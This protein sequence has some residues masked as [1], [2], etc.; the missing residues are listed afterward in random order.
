MPTR[1]VS[2]GNV[3]VWWVTSIADPNAPTA[4]EI[5]AGK[6][7]SE[8]ISWNNFELGSSGSADVDD[9]SIVDV[10]NATSRGFPDF[11][12]TLAFFREK[13][14]SDTT[15]IYQQA[16]DTFRDSGLKGFLVVRYAQAA[17]GTPAVA[18]QI[19][20]AYYFE[21]DR[22]SDDTEGEDSVK[23]EVNF[24][25]QAILAEHVVVKTAAPVVV[26]PATLAL[27]VDEIGIASAAVGGHPMASEADW[28]SSAPNIASVSSRGV[29]VGISAGTA[30]ITATHPGGTTAGTVTVTVS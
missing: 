3:T 26:A 8:A 17:P 25:P 30:T 24:L 9:R 12:A 16:F 21:T 2:N 5:N 4:A 6:D 1:I 28:I 14:A 19:V 15:S 29:I 20:S 18:G 22:I 10:G 27:D 7:F 23:F 11:S 13:N